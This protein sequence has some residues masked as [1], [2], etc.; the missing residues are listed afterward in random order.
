M[1]KQLIIDSILAIS[2]DLSIKVKSL[3]ESIIIQSSKT[4]VI[5]LNGKIEGINIAIED[6]RR[7]INQIN[8]N[9]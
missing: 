9:E 8:E 3:K 2:E 7:L 6:L 5:R 1:D 4:Q